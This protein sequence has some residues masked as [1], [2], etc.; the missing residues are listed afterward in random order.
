VYVQIWPRQH[1]GQKFIQK[2]LHAIVILSCLGFDQGGLLQKFVKT[3]YDRLTNAPC[4]DTEFTLKSLGKKF[5]CNFDLKSSQQIPPPIFAFLGTRGGIYTL[6][7]RITCQ[8]FYHGAAGDQN[9]T[10]KFLKIIIYAGVPY[11]KSGEVV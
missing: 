11:L 7:L 8:A 5:Y 4:H 2:A 3:S 6:N 9:T 1:L 10:Y